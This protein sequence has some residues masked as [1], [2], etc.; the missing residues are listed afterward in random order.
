MLSYLFCEPIV[1]IPSS[2]P[3]PSPPLP[4]LYSE[5]TDLRGFFLFVCFLLL[6]CFLLAYLN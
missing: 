5:T 6:F 4:S 1:N 2:S 3:L